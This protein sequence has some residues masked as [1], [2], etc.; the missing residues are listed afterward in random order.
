MAWEEGKHPVTNSRDVFKDFAALKGELSE[1][2]AR[3]TLA[4]FLQHNPAFLVDLL[5]GFEITPFQEI[6]LKAW[7]RNDYNMAV[8]GRGCSKTLAYNSSSILLARGR[9]L[10]TLP[11]L[12]PNVDFS[13][14]GWV[15]INPVELWNGEGWRLTSKIYVQPGKEC[16]RVTTRDGF[17][18]EGSVRH[19][20]K[21]LNPQ[22]LAIEWKRYHDLKEGDHICIS[23]NATEWHRMEPVNQADLDE[24]YLVGLMI[25]DGCYA[26]SAKGMKITSMDEEILSFVESRYPCQKRGRKQ[27]TNAIDLPLR[28]P[29]ASDLMAKHGLKQVLSY[30]KEIPQTLM[31]DRVLLR[32]CLVGLFDTDGCISIKEGTVRFDT[33]SK[34]LAHQVQVSLL[35]FGIIAR[36]KERKTPSSFGRSYAVTITGDNIVT[37]SDLVGF[38]LARKR[39]VLNLHLDKKRNTNL[40]VVP[41]A[42]EYAQREIKSKIRLNEELSREWRDCIRRKSK[43]CHLSYQTLDSYIEFFQRAGVSN[44]V[45][46]PL[47]CLKREHFFF[48]PVTKIESFQHDCLDFNVPF[49]ERYWSNGFISHNSWTVALFALIWAIYNPNNRV[50]VVS[51]AFRASRRILEQ[52]EKFVNDKAAGPLRA[53]FPDKM[54]QKT[55]EWIWTLPNGST[56]RCLPLG[57][58]TKIRGVRADTLIVDEFA[59][60]PEPVI[61]E[62]L[63]PFLAA[64]NKI[65]EKIKTQK[66]EDEEIAAGTR[67][68]NDRTIVQESVKV[69]FLSSACY[70]FEHMYKRYNDWIE[71][72]RSDK[73]RGISFFVSRVGFDGVS[74]EIINWKAVEEAQQNSS[75]AMFD[76]EWRAIFTPDSGGYFKASKM[77]ICTVPDGQLP[78]LELVGEKGA[79]YIVT[80]DTS[81]SGSEESDHFAICVLKIVKRADGVKIPMLVHSYAVAG[82][83]LSEHTLYFHYILTHFNVVYIA[84]DASQGDNVEFL[85]ASVQSA[86]FKAAKIE[87]SDIDAE[88]SKDDFRELPKQIKR[89][90]NRTIGRIVHKQPFSSDW[91]RAANE[92]M[93]G[94]FDHKTVLFA[95]KIAAES[96]AATR[97]NS[98]GHILEPLQRGHSDFKDA[99]ITDFINRQD[100]LVDLVK[101]ECSLIQVRTTELGTQQFGLPQSIKRSTG[102]NRMRKDSYSALLLGVWATK[103]Y[104]ESQ[105]VEVQTG[106][107]DFIYGW[108]R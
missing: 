91:Q 93:Q 31:Q 45:L 27:G 47:L 108:A 69:I 50:V 90:Y 16:L 71:N 14:E 105:T 44:A 68:A 1:E 32:E 66:R 28:V 94:C 59:Y 57:D 46:E 26:K 78:T 103:V 43:Q 67:A 6:I 42:K 17:Y 80:I 10:I 33:V 89:S 39:A 35:T 98:L 13:K 65:Q 11:E 41:G 74:P 4:E 55:D 52:C 56:I 79:E 3:A 104:L 107:P 23:R 87:L 38:R 34:T 20:V 5:A 97:A 75:E 99:T 8:W 60:L 64:S 73:E 12:L 15:D 40:D 22:T 37:F 49:G 24:A 29:F 7:M 62:V 9:G 85:N 18:L 63:Q 36:I 81:A 70:Q 100:H 84:I 83:D 77:G 106:S 51:F 2:Q 86:L 102:P 21:V 82:G 53:C 54:R 95:G 19:L 101:K 76:R 48:S 92:Y 30:D 58:G 88:F 96:G 72:I 25:G 61:N